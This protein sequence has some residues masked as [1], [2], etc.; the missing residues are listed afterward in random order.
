MN[1][2]LFLKK[3]VLPKGVA[4]VVFGA[5]SELEHAIIEHPDVR[6]ISFT[7]S[8][9]TGRRLRNLVDVTLKKCHLKWVV[10][11]RLSLWMTRMS[12]LL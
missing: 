3:W 5:G 7:G 8:T 6:V 1:W 4:N 12:N 11:M 10:K 9:D 2:R